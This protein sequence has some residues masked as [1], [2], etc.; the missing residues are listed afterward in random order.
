MVKNQARIANFTV[1]L[2]VILEVSDQL[3]LQIEALPHPA[4]EACHA[5]VSALID[6]WEQ[7]FA[8]VCLSVS[9][10]V[11]DRITEHAQTL[12]AALQI[13]DL[14]GFYESLALL[15]DAVEDLRRMENLSVVSLL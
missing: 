12:S 5:R 8:A 15:R 13:G 10:T 2:S 14:Y 4:D 11:A 1:F 7:Q 6:F 9:Y 3:L